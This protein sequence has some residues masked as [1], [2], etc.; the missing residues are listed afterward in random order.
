MK[1]PTPAAALF[2][3]LQNTQKRPTK[4]HFWKDAVNRG[5]NTLFPGDHATTTVLIIRLRPSSCP[6]PVF[7][8][9][10]IYRAK[11]WQLLSSQSAQLLSLPY[12]SLF[13]QACPR[14]VSFFQEFVV[15][16]FPSSLR[17]LKKNPAL[18]DILRQCKLLCF[19]CQRLT[20]SRVSTATKA[21]LEL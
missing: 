15:H 21:D 1:T 16:P 13:T 3:P 20:S 10:L 2:Y 6:P 5:L 9:A 12:M 7:Q 4:R 17:T 8:A 19:S 14:F 11:P 18:S